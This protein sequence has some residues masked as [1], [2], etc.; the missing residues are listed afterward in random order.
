V[1]SDIIAVLSQL[2]LCSLYTFVQVS[3]ND[4]IMLVLFVPIVQF[5]MHRS[6]VARRSFQRAANFGG[7]LYRRAAVGRDN[8]TNVAPAPPRAGMV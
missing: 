4:L 6:L 5:L 3:V 2:P 7:G 1:I 8:V